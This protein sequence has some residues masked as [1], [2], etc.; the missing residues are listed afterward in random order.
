MKTSKPRLFSYTFIIS[1]LS[2]A[3]FTACESDDSVNL[4]CKTQDFGFIR[5]MPL[6]GEPFPFHNDE[7]LIFKDSLDHE[8]RFE[9]DSNNVSSFYTGIRSSSTAHFECTERLAHLESL[10]VKFLSDSS[11]FELTCSFQANM[12]EVN[13]TA[14]FYDGMYPTITDINTPITEWLLTLSYIVNTRGNEA[15]V[16]FHPHSQFAAVKNFLGKDFSKVYSKYE[17]DGSELHFN[18]EL[19]FVAFRREHGT[20]WMLDRTE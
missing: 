6:P 5:L 8:L 20:L 15:F 19:G 2:L 9:M 13:D 7:A 11:D 10:N 12:A 14:Y 4:P 17:D 16:D 18:H 1:L 3:F